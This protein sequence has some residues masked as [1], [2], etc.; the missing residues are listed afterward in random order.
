MP[1][2]PKHDDT[3]ET[4]PVD[5]DGDTYHIRSW[6]NTRLYNRTNALI[7]DSNIA[8]MNQR[9]KDVSLEETMERVTTAQMEIMKIWLVGWSHDDDFTVSNIER[10][11]RTHYAAVRKAID[12]RMSVHKGVTYRDPLLVTSENSHGGEPSESK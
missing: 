8:I 11:P 12:V 2:L 1:L 9:N 7:A 6:V 4:I 5:I 3:G 10:M